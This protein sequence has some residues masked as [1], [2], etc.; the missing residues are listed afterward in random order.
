MQAFVGNEEGDPELS[1]ATPCPKIFFFQLE[2][3]VNSEVMW[4]GVGG[5]ASYL[6][7]KKIFLIL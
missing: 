3:N 7:V 1:F 2:K 4:N 6:Q 5:V